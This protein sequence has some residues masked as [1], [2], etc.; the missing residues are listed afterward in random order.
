M[1]AALRLGA[2]IKNW[3]PNQMELEL[4]RLSVSKEYNENGISSKQY[5][6]Q[7]PFFKIC[8]MMMKICYIYTMEY[9]CS[10]K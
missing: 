6:T 7:F 2:L 8:P 5:T 9:W 3:H 1:K 10:I 4:H